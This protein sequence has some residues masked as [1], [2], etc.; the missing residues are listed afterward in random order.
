MSKSVVT[1][2]TELARFWG[3]DL[4]E[5]TPYQ[6]QLIAGLFEELK[7]RQQMVGAKS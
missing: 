6:L 5:L 4:T 1:S 3:T 2:N 7:K